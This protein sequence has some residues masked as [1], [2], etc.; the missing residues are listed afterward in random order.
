MTTH[1][2]KRQTTIPEIIY[3]TSWFLTLGLLLADI[4]KKIKIFSWPLLAETYAIIII[5]III[6]SSIINAG[7]KQGNV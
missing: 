4:L 6:A 2:K 1:P 7:R 3:A 5:T